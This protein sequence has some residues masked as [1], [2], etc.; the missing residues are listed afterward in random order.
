MLREDVVA[1][2]SAGRFHVRT[3]TSVDEAL[4]LMT[5][6]AAGVRGLEGQWPEGSV[7][8]RVDARL[9][10]LAEALQRFGEPEHR[11]HRNGRHPA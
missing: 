9:R 4:Q 6:L 1:A 5:G 3:V 2:V 8:A 10:S 7:H 11:P